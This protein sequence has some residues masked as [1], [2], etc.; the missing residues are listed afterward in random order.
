M[1]IITTKIS[2]TNADHGDS[3]DDSSD[4]HHVTIVLL[5]LLMKLNVIGPSLLPPELTAYLRNRPN[6][7]FPLEVYQEARFSMNG[8]HAATIRGTPKYRNSGPWNDCVLVSYEDDSGE[9][10]EYPFQVH[11]FFREEL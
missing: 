6:L 8:K 7:V 1:L 11:G 9:K 3:R 4:P 10:K 5:H 2:N